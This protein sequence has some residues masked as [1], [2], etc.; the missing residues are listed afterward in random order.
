ML[1]LLWTLPTRLDRR[2]CLWWGVG[3]V[4]G[5]GRPVLLWHAACGAEPQT[6]RSRRLQPLPPRL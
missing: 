4:L 3:S 1:A 6:G 5:G 2:A